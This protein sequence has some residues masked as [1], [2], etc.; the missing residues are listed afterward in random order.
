MALSLSLSFTPSLSFCPCIRAVS[1]TTDPIDRLSKECLALSSRIIMSII[2][3]T[4]QYFTAL[5][6]AIT[7]RQE[8]N[9]KSFL[10]EKQS[11]YNAI[12]LF[13]YW[14][15]VVHHRE[16][17]SIEVKCRQRELQTLILM[18][19]TEGSFSLN[20]MFVWDELESVGYAVSCLQTEETC[21]SLPFTR[22]NGRQL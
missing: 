12:I 15:V 4:H 18:L 10:D 8:Y 21:L 22:L 20:L 16:P 6:L 19:D 2:T 5:S 11:I 14:W 3:S 9:G 1:F 17:N 7:W 13:F